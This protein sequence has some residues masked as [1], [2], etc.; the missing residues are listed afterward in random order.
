MLRLIN[1]EVL[2]LANAWNFVLCFMYN[3][4]KLRKTW[5]KGIMHV[6]TCSM[7]FPNFARKVVTSQF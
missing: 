4:G 7:E 5:V 6:S 3:F 2:R 1:V